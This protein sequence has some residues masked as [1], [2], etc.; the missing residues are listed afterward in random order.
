MKLTRRLAG[1]AAAVLAALT[2]ALCLAGPSQ[3]A[4]GHYSAA[5]GRVL[6]HCHHTHACHPVPAGVRHFY[7]I[8]AGD[9]ARIQYGDTTRTWWLDRH[10]HVHAET[11]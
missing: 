5:W 2:L 4:T 7:G 6:R 10:G 9:P 1:I 11:S 3:A 8:P